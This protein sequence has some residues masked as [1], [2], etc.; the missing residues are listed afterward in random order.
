MRPHPPDGPSALRGL[1]FDPFA[2]ISGDMTVAAL[3]DLGLPLEWL[4]SFV[5]SLKLGDVRV[6]ADPF[7]AVLAIPV[8]NR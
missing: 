8:G 6:G 1:I 4:Q 2:G 7:P 5:A 3:L